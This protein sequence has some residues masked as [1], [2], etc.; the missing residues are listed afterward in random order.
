MN[1]ICSDFKLCI[2]SSLDSLRAFQRFS[3][4]CSYGRKQR[5]TTLIF[6]S[7]R[8]QWQ[9]ARFI[10]EQRNTSLFLNRNTKMIRVK[11]HVYKAK[12]NS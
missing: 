6:N 11:G 1:S 4:I 10:S 12:E 8:T 9:N 5:H 7:E 2:C 3:G